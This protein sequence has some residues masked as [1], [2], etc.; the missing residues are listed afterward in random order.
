M[1][2]GFIIE[3]RDLGFCFY[4]ALTVLADTSVV[5]FL[6]ISLAECHRPPVEDTVKHFDLFRS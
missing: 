1:Y 2:T 4:A 5:C 6:G 3:N